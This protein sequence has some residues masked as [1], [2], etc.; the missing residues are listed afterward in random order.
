MYRKLYLLEAICVGNV[1]W[2]LDILLGYRC[3][4]C[5]LT[6]ITKRAKRTWFLN[7][8]MGY[9]SSITS[10]PV[11]E[12]QHWILIGYT[13]GGLHYNGITGHSLLQNTVDVRHKTALCRHICKIKHIWKKNYEAVNPLSRIFSYIIFF[14]TRI[15]LVYMISSANLFIPISWRFNKRFYVTALQG[16]GPRKVFTK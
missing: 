11:I 5:H 12:G 8:I 9:Q 13:K 14:G 2:T 10:L 15:S 6:G 7:V 1:F 16:C 3:F 4:S